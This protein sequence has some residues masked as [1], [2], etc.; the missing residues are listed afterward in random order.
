MLTGISGIGPKA[1]LAVLSEF[2]PDSFI[3]SEAAGYIA[4]ARRLC[5]R[6]ALVMF[7]AR[8]AKNITRLKGG[9]NRAVGAI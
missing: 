7:F 6:F 1:A 2:T 4:A 5:P 8:R 3:R 9:Y